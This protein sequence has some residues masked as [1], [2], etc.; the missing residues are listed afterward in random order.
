MKLAARRL[1][2]FI[3]LVS[4]IALA[5]LPRSFCQGVQVSAE[6][7]KRL[8]GVVADLRDANAAYQR[9][10]GQ[11]QK[12]ID[13]LRDALRESSER[14]TTKLGDFTTREEMKKIADNIQ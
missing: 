6:D 5:P 9:R 8:V 11:M 7:F 12:E 10:I 14:T 4:L 1:S 2:V 3:L 13:A